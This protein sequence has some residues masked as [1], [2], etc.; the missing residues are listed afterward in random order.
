M[1]ETE[2]DGTDEDHANHTIQEEL[3]IE[4]V[5]FPLICTFAFFRDIFEKM[6]SV[7]DKIEVDNGDGNQEDNFEDTES[8]DMVVEEEEVIDDGDKDDGELRLLQ[9]LDVDV[10]FM[11]FFL[12]GAFTVAKTAEVKVG[13]DE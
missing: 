8:V 5:S 12:Y 2:E 6:V 11:S 3:F 1:F 13:E 7:V 9:S 4:N 10:M